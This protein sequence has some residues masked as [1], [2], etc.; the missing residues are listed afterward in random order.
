MQQFRIFTFWEPSESIPAYLR[1]CMKTW[2]RF[3]PEYEI[4]QL[5]YTNI[6]KWIGKD[7][8]D[9]S[10]YRN[11]SLPQQADAVRCAVLRRHGGIWL[12]TDTVITSSKINKLI[13]TDAEFT[14]I[15]RHVAFLITVQNTD[16]LTQWQQQIN[17]KLQTF[18]SFNML[19]KYFIR[20]KW[21]ALGNSIL[22]T[23]LDNNKNIV[24]TIDKKSIYACPEVN[25]GKVFNSLQEQYIDFYFSNDYSDYLLE[26]E[27]GIVLLHNSWTPKKYKKMSEEQFLSQHT[28]LAKVLKYIIE[29]SSPW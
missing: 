1:L 8:F 13:D 3:L 4:V 27:H 17:D 14:L 18:N 16:L 19:R 9:N 25:Y 10:L 26:K 15:G 21:D 28:T 23:L 2:V 24:K 5:N 11:F 7:C 12:D 29:G 20:R 6:D 22:N